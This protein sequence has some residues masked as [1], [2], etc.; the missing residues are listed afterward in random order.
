MQGFENHYKHIVKNFEK[1]M[2]KML[3]C[4]NIIFKKQKKKTTACFENVSSI[5]T[6]NHLKQVRTS[7]LKIMQTLC[8]ST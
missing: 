5:V 2:Y 4:R 7:T 3:M 8:N 1:T 6:T